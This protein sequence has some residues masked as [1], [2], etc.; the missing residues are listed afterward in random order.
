MGCE[1]GTDKESINCIQG[2]T[3]TFQ[4][5]RP[6]MTKEFVC[7]YMSNNLKQ[8]KTSHEGGEQTFYTNI[9]G[10]TKTIH[11]AMRN[12]QSEVS[13]P[14]MSLQNCMRS[15]ATM[16]ITINKELGTTLTVIVEQSIDFYLSSVI[17]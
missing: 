5:H 16:S 7:M 2:N 4:E 8:M 3:T 15:W 14:S 13:T 17:G 9:S 12:T 1:L 10:S 6:Y 11:S